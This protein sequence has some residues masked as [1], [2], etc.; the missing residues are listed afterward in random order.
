M[1]PLAL[2]RALLPL[3]L[4]T[5]AFAPF[6]QLPP[7]LKARNDSLPMVIGLLTFGFQHPADHLADL[8]DHITP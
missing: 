5:P 4:N 8:H 7:Q 2:E 1:L 3:T 6:V